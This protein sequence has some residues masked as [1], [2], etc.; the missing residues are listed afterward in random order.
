MKVRV[1]RPDGSTAKLEVPNNATLAHL[2][3]QVAVSVMSLPA[4]RWIET[5]LSLNKKVS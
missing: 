4:T 3:E 1:R 5:V 2:K